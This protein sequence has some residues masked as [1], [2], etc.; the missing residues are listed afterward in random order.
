[1]KIKTKIRYLK[2]CGF[3][4]LPYEIM[5]TTNFKLTYFCFNFDQEPTLCLKMT[6]QKLTRIFEHVFF[7]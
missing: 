2:I 7:C 4:I 1:M 3:H 6:F 5:I